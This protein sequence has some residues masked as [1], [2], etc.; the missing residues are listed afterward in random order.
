MEHLDIWLDY[1]DI[2][3]AMKHEQ[4]EKLFVKS[5][6]T[7]DEK[8]PRDI[9][10]LRS[11]ESLFANSPYASGY[12]PKNTMDVRVTAFGNKSGRKITSSKTLDRI[13]AVLYPAV[14]LK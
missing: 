3:G 7:I 14:Y 13:R 8:H 11:G 5:G 10:F 9:P 1:E 4:V 6:E 2:D 12:K